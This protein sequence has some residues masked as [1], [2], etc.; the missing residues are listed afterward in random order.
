MVDVHIVEDARPSGLLQPRDQLC[1][2]D[3]DLPVQ[4]APLVGN[5]V[6]LARQIGDEVLEVGVGQ[7]CE[8]GQRLHG[9]PFLVE[10]SQQ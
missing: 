3:V 9:P 6:L 1:T 5:L 4:E 8:I 7:R 10:G 2:E